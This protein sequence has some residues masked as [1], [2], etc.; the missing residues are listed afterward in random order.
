M[1]K[2]EINLC[3]RENEDTCA[4]VIL[5]KNED[6]SES[7]PIILPDYLCL[8]DAETLTNKIKEMIESN[9]KTIDEVKKYFYE[10]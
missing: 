2:C 10:E 9:F 4:P 5:V 8:K 7:F 1:L 6:E 3:K